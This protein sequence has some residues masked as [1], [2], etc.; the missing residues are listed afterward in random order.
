M[1]DSAAVL[2]VG[3]LGGSGTRVVADL[4]SAMGVFMGIKL[5]ESSDNLLFTLLF[6]NPVWFATATQDQIHYRLHLFEKMTTGVKLNLTEKRDLFQ[7]SIRAEHVS[8]RTSLSTL[9]ASLDSTSERTVNSWGWKEPN[10]Q[11]FIEHLSTYFSSFKYIQVIRH[12]LDMAFSSNRQQVQNWSHLF[13]LDK[14][15]K[16]KNSNVLQLDYWI[17]SN[18]Y[19][20]E[21]GRRLLGPN[22]YLLNYDQLCQNPR[23]EIA[24]L[25]AFLAIHPS[26]AQQQ[27]LIN[28]VH[29]SPSTN[30]YKQRDLTVFSREQL[31]QVQALGFDI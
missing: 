26:A 5:N 19:V 29:V 22:F 30:R 9:L 12:G 15:D 24:A 2:A 13:D 31:A 17:K 27:T 23:Q 3:S 16:S 4:L 8:I 18:Q 10:T 14:L 1:N 20:I 25:C 7:I 6:K 11:L 21:T 28:M